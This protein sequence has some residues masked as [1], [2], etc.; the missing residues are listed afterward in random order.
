MKKYTII[1]Y[2]AFALNAISEKAYTQG[3][4]P[5]RGGERTL[6]IGDS[7]IDFFGPVYTAVNEIYKVADPKFIPIYNAGGGKGCGRMKEYVVWGTGKTGTGAL[8]SIR[9]AHFDYVFV[10]PENDAVDV[11]DMADEYMGCGGPTGYPKNQ[12]TLI[13]YYKIYDAEVRKNKSTLVLWASHYAASDYVNETTKAK[14][15]YAKLQKQH[16]VSYFMPSYLAWDSVR[17]DFPAAN[18]NCPPNGSGFIKML[19]SDCGH[20]NGNGMA[21]DAYTLYSIYTGGLSAKGLNPKFPSPME[22]PSIRDYLAGVGCEI[23]RKI[24]L[25]MGFPNDFEAPSTPTQLAASNITNVSFDLTWK[26]STDNKAVA[27]Y[28][29]Y[30]DEVLYHTTTGTSTSLPIRSLGP[31]INYKINIKAY[32]AAGH[33]TVYS[34][35][36]NVKTTGLPFV[37]NGSFET[38]KVTGENNNPIGSSWT[39]SGGTTGIYVNDDNERIDGLQSAYINKLGQSVQG[40]SQEINLAAGKYKCTFYT[41]M[42]G[43]GGINRP[44]RFAVGNNEFNINLREGGKLQKQIVPFTVAASGKTTIK[45]YVPVIN[46]DQVYAT[47]DNIKIEIVDDTPLAIATNNFIEAEQQYNIFPNPSN[48]EVIIEGVN[49]RQEVKIYNTTGELMLQ[50]QS[51]KFSVREWNSGLYLIVISQKE[52]TKRFKIEVIH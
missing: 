28:E 32:D 15:C 20:Q 25:S 9:N 24:L 40:F 4:K 52:K 50:T 39:F 42:P 3:F 23:G 30:I 51:N 27:G 45:F 38:P 33:F 13:K 41:Y 44:M 29:V 49:G 47:I 12:D 37:T 31:G 46:S 48:N 35:T 18:N 26:A 34:I 6:W 11:Y 10:Q 16:K 17:T 19:Y 36:L 7:Y 8:D 14:E 1:I 5:M 22:T 43:W 2:I 21:L